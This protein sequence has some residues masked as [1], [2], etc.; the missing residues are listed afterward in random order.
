LAYVLLYFGSGLP[1]DKFKLLACPF[2]NFLEIF[3]TSINIK[4]SSP[5]VAAPNNIN[6]IT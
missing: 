1:A 2:L 3:L 4:C 5:T 6:V